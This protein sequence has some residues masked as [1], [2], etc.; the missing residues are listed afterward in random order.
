[1]GKLITSPVEKFPGTVI[2]FDP[3]PYPAYIAWKKA[4]ESIDIKQSDN[5]EMQLII[6]GGIRAMVEKWD[7][8]GYDIANPAAV[9]NRG[10]ILRLLSW[11]TIEISTVIAG[12]S[13][14]N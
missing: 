10:A 9:P 3:V 14:P 2:L 12:D 4:F 11:L 13:D 7:I 6:W 1:M 8:P 5:L